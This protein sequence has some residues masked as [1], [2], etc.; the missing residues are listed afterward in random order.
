MGW[1]WPVRDHPRVCGEHWSPKSIKTEPPGSSPRVRGT[2]RHRAR[3]S[4]RT[5]IIPA[6]AG[7]T[8]HACAPV[9]D[10][11]DHPRVCGEH[12]SIVKFCL[13][14][15]G[16]SP[17]VRGTHD[18]GDA[19]ER[20]G[21]IIPACAGNTSSSTAKSGKTGDHPR[22]C[23]EHAI[24]AAMNES[25]SGSSPRVRGTLYGR[26]VRRRPGGIIPA[27]AGNT[28]AQLC[29]DI[30]R[31]DHPRVCGEHPAVIAA[32]NV[33]AGSSPRV[34]G[35][36]LLGIGTG[37]GAGIIPACAGNTRDFW[38]K[39]SDVGD[40]PRVCGEHRRWP[41]ADG[42]RPGIIPACAGNTR[43]TE[44][45]APSSRDHPRV[46]GEHQK[47]GADDLSEKGSSPRVRG[48]PF[49]SNGLSI[50][51]GIIPACAGNTV[52]GWKFR[53][54]KGDHPRVCGE[55]CVL[56]G[57]TDM[58]SGSSP[59]V[60]GTPGRRLSSC[61][62]R[63]I[64][65]ACAG[66]TIESSLPSNIPWDHPRVCGEHV[67]ERRSRRGFKGSSPRVRGTL[68]PRYPTMIC[69]GIIPA[70]AGNTHGN[71][72]T[73]PLSRDHPRVC[74][75]HFFGIRLPYWRKG[76]SPRVRGTRE[77]PVRVGVDA[78]IIPACAGNTI[79]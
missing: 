51:R 56:I 39:C 62:Q 15:P 64:I 41:C 72:I 27:C 42:R 71:G 53:R 8:D 79:A 7:N 3:D 28:S 21:G 1:W 20:F 38:R 73:R 40:H 16:S 31:R 52:R 14:K 17:R 58:A 76:S 75:E 2:Q 33:E 29:A 18:H 63:G 50:D 10:S 68:P 69:R 48:T 19:F 78:G 45:T 44:A 6:C 65:P 77:L 57:N 30:A 9:R 5:G 60:R 37:V 34:R 35:T 47:N 11:R 49:G 22:V 13:A 46:C 36:R 67:V 74:G 32:L 26:R 43:R 66:N 4:N 70:C 23:G 12:S 59:R 54:S 61:R 24:K 55:H 25:S